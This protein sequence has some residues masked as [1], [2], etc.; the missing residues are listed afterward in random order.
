M[1]GI[2]FVIAKLSMATKLKVRSG[3]V[4]ELDAGFYGYAGSALGGLEP[5][6]ARHLKAEKRHFWHIDYLMDYAKVEKIICV[7]T[8]KKDECLIVQALTR[9]LIS[10]PGFGCSDCKCRS[11]LF[12]SY[13]AAILESRAISALK[14]L[15]PYQIIL[16]V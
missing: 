13:E 6:I 10:I 2:Y 16:S 3:R 9:S 15:G 14:Q 4:F 12:F 11:H 1:T 8:R 7:E 5:R